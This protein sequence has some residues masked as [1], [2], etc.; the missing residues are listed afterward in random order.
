[1]IV[2]QAELDLVQ[3]GKRTLML[4]PV[5]KGPDGERLPCPVEEEQFVKLQP[6]MFEKGTGVTIVEVERVRFDDLT[7]TDIGN[8]G[9]PAP[10]VKALVG[11]R[12]FWA[13][14]FVLGNFVWFFAKHRERFLSRGGITTDVD[15]HIL[16]EPGVTRDEE[17]AIAAAAAAQRELEDEQRFDLCRQQ[18]QAALDLMRANKDADPKDLR[19]ME[20][21]LKKMG[22]SRGERAA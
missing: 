13:V 7:E 9:R 17:L 21:R 1:M 8:L 12:E 2:T 14:R 20:A 3:D 18:I 4:L 6:G 19:F 5:E 22:R 10:M 11:D 16:E 15:R